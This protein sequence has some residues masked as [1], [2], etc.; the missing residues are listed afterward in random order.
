MAAGS[1]QSSEAVV[2]G[3]V[4]RQTCSAVLARPSRASPGA[5]AGSFEELPRREKPTRGGARL[6]VDRLLAAL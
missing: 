2:D 5:E 6:A 1:C 3:R 4:V